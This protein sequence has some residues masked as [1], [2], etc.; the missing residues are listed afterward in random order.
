VDRRQVPLRMSGVRRGRPS[1]RR[2]MA[3]RR[4]P[5]NL[6]RGRSGR[7]FP[8]RSGGRRLVRT[9]LMSWDVFDARIRT[10]E[11]QRL[12]MVFGPTNQVRRRAVRTVDLEDL[13]LT[14]MLANVVSHDD[15]LVTHLR[16]HR[17][18]LPV[19]WS[20]YTIGRLPHCSE[21]EDRG[22]S[23]PV[24]HAVGRNRIDGAAV[25]EGPHGGELEE[26]TLRAGNVVARPAGTGRPHTFRAGDGGLSVLAYGTREAGDVTY[27][28]RSGKVNFRGVGLIGR[29][30]VLDYW[31]GED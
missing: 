6:T 25:Q 1:E 3:R 20:T 5:P 17:L 13:G 12:M 2:R 11:H 23:C 22:G 29:L 30:D 19:S 8:I 7:A 18:P 4:E 27:Y 24:G 21:A 31:D 26:H 10:R 14:T 9:D 28:P 16:L 15:Q